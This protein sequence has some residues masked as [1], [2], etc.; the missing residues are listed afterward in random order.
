MVDGADTGVWMSGGGYRA[1]FGAPASASVCWSMINQKILYYCSGQQEIGGLQMCVC[2]FR[3][4]IIYLL[5]VGG[6]G[7]KDLAILYLRD[8]R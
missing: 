7:F 5:L 2:Y 1:L 8:V 4:Y 3:C 6:T